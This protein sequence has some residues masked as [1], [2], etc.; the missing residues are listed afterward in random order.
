MKSFVRKAPVMAEYDGRQF[1]DVRDFLACYPNGS[2]HHKQEIYRSWK[3]QH[4]VEKINYD[5]LFQMLYDICWIVNG[6]ANY[7]PIV[8]KDG[9]VFWLNYGHHTVLTNLDYLLF[10]VRVAGSHSLLK[11]GLGWYV[12]TVRSHVIRCGRD[13]KPTPEEKVIFST[14]R[15]DDFC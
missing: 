10:G 15:R 7:S 2:V 9:W 8:L 4:I 1:V 5:V 12:S 3:G 14:F 6:Q 11:D 13:Y